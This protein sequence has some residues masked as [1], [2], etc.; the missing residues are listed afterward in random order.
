LKETSVENTETPGN[1]GQA[2]ELLRN[3]R[4]EVIGLLFNRHVFRTHQ[5]IVRRNPRL[6]GRPRSIF[7][8]WVGLCM[9]LRTLLA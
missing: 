2:A 8:E 4:E 3:I 6:Q 7:P 5:E 1:M 9:Q